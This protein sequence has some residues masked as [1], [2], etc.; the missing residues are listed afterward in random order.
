MP[1]Q[2]SKRPIVLAYR[3]P[4]TIKRPPPVNPKRACGFCSRVRRALGMKPL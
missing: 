2:P 3:P 1:R 4:T